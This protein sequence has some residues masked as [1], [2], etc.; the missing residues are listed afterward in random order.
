[1]S[2]RAR[3]LRVSRGVSASASWVSSVSSSARASARRSRADTKV[4]VMS[5]VL[6]LRDLT[7][8]SSERS[9]RASESLPAGIARSKRAIERSPALSLT[10]EETT[11][12]P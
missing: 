12:P 10:C 3:M 5:S 9:A 11:M 2:I 1:M 8:A 4:S 6:S 7:S